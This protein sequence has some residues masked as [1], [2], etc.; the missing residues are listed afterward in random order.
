VQYGHVKELCE[1]LPVGATDAALLQA[2][3]SVVDA[4]IAKSPDMLRY[5]NPTHGT[6]SLVGWCGER[7]SFCEWWW[8][9]AGTTIEVS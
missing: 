1:A 4:A 2:Y 5:E 7:R 3:L 8:H 9:C 6:Q